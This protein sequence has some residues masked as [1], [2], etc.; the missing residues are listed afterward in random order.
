[1]NLPEHLPPEAALALHDLF[2]DLAQAVWNQYEPLL[3]PLCIAQDRAQDYDP[4]TYEDIDPPDDFGD[5]LP[6]L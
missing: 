5:Q 6:L 3:V 4:I 2:A 1:M